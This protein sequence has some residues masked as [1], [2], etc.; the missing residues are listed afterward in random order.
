MYDL[1]WKKSRRSAPNY[2]VVPVCHIPSVEVLSQLS[3][4]ETQ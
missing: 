1:G 3:G 4:T 2:T